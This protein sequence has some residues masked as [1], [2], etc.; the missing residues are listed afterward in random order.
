MPDLGPGQ[1]LE[2]SEAF[3]LSFSLYLR[4]SNLKKGKLPVLGPIQP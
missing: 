2:C 3:D 1:T 4:D